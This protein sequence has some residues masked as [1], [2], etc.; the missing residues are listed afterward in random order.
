[1]AYIANQ[2]PADVF[3]TI[4]RNA[5]LLLTD[6]DPENWTVERNNIKGATSGGIKFSDTPTYVDFGEDI[7]NCPKNMMELKELEDREVKVEG[8]YVAVRP[9]E[10]KDLMGAA[11]IA[12]TTIT[13]RN[14]LKT[15]DFKKLW[16]VCDYGKDN[17]I[18]L[19]ID[20]V[21]NTNGFA[22]QTADKGKGQFGFSYL[23][24]YS[25]KAPETVPYKFHFKSE[26]VAAASIGDE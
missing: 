16:F 23:A 9:E 6:F 2:L 12:G 20:N 7:D 13:P 3:D 19:E 26:V 25:V 21:L 15:E 24:H 11:D 14:Q 1:M 10:V 5:G 4:Q 18:A 8:T 17:A 22:L